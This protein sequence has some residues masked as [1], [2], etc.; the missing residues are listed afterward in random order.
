M[1]RKWFCFM[2]VVTMLLSMAMTAWAADAKIDKVTI[3]ITYGQEPKSGN[4]I[5]SVTAKVGGN[6]PYT[7]DYAEYISENDVWVVGDRPL[8]R[9][10]LTAKSGSKFSYTSKSHFSLSGGNATFKKARIYD[11]GI[12]MEVELYLKRIGGTLSGVQNLEWSDTLACWDHLEGAKEY[13]VRLFRDERSVV[14]VKTTD[15]SY[16]FASNMDKEGTYSFRVRA[17]ASYNNRTGEWSDYSDDYY[18]DEDEV[19]NYT[20]GGTWRQD[21]RGMWYSYYGGGY[22]R[23]C[24]KIID[25]AYYYFDGDGYMATGWRRVDGNTYYLGNDGRMKTDW[26]AVDG[27]WYYMDG[28]GA[29]TTGWQFVR[30]SWYYMDSNG[31]MLTGWQKIGGE[32][33]YL[34]ASGAM[35]TGWQLINGK[36]YYMDGSGVMYAN[37]YT[38]DGHYVDASGAMMW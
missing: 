18:L 33:Y 20:G 38:P 26:Q 29:R 35:T 21:G 8:V 17:I 25:N 3:E 31:V 32:W 28:S 7:V 16:S 14:T 27:K 24:W 37:R 34:N 12:Q 36:Y 5:G 11:D 2:M 4:E 22:P 1:K 30:G 23:S 6:E 19:W 10:Q 15:N 13:E 9:V